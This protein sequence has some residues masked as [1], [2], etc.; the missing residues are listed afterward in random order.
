MAAAYGQDEAAARGNRRPGLCCDNRGTLSCDSF[1]ARKD[2]DFHTSLY[3][4]FQPATAGLYQ[5]P[6]E[7][8]LSLR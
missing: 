5:P 2:F 7:S 4:L 3:N 6:H 1:G 8:A